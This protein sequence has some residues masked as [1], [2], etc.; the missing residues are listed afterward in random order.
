VVVLLGVVCVDGVDGMLG[1][2]SSLTKWCGCAGGWSRERGGPGTR[3]P[4]SEGLFVSGI[5]WGEWACGWVVWGFY[6]WWG[7]GAW[8]WVKVGVVCVGGSWYIWKAPQ[9]CD[10]VAEHS[11]LCVV[12]GHSA[13]VVG[14]GWRRARSLW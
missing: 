10:D 4:G 1:G 5:G 14:G 6:S 13:F 7:Q 3:V 12:V 11:A 8:L 2:V 9:L